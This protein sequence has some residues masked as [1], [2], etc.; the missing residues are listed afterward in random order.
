MD[1]FVVYALQVALS[2]DSVSTMRPMDNV[3]ATPYDSGEG[4]TA[5]IYGKGKINNRTKEKIYINRYTG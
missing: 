4:N 2:K 5:I 1:Q 3:M